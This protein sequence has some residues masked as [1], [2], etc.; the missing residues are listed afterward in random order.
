M[1][2]SSVNFLSL[3]KAHAVINLSLKIADFPHMPLAIYYSISYLIHSTK[4][5]MRNFD[6]VSIE[7]EEAREIE[8]HSGNSSGTPNK[9]GD[10]EDA[11]DRKNQPFVHG[12]W[13]SLSVCGNS[14][15]MHSV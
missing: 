3:A 2:L 6:I 15:P 11:P 1:C 13:Y 7:K 12:N 9:G 5:V 8:T 4:R 14:V 10:I